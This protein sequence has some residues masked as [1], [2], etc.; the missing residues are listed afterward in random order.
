MWV[1]ETSYE[2]NKNEIISALNHL[3]QMELS[4]I[5]EP[6]VRLALNLYSANSLDF[7]DALIAF[8][9]KTHGAEF[10]ATFDKKAAKTSNYKIIN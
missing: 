1:L 6:A 7:A 9:N 2:Y 4:I 5:D 8:I 10:T 3:L